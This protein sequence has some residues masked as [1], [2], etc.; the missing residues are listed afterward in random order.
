MTSSG[1][2]TRCWV[3][4]CYVYKRPS[5]RLSKGTTRTNASGFPDSFR[6]RNHTEF[7]FIFYNLACRNKIQRIS[8]LVSVETIYSS[9]PDCLIAIFRVV[10]NIGESLSVKQMRCGISE[11]WRAMLYVQECFLRKSKIIVWTPEIKNRNQTVSQKNC[12]V[13]SRDDFIESE[14][15]SVS[16]LYPLDGDFYITIF[17]SPQL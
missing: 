8:H 10:D 3:T 16:R 12:N 13:K 15:T 6:Y 7:S 1:V 11:C 17:H 4:T 5:E 14:V 9:F 2:K